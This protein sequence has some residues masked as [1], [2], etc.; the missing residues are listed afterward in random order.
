MKPLVCVNTEDIF[1]QQVKND[2]DIQKGHPLTHLVTSYRSIQQHSTD[3]PKGMGGLRPRLDRAV[4]KSPYAEQPILVSKS[5]PNQTGAAV[6][7][8][9]HVSKSSK[10]HREFLMATRSPVSSHQHFLTIRKPRTNRLEDVQQHLSTPNSLR[11]WAQLA[12]G[13][14]PVVDK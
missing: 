13:S 8:C 3:G 12:P 7:K 1:F 14:E 5:N 6:R 2:F 4:N 9:H 10:H 11:A